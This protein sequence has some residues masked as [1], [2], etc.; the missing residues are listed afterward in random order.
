MAVTI[1]YAGTSSNTANSTFYKS[2]SI[3]AAVG[4]LLAVFVAASGT[5]QR[6]GAV[7]TSNQPLD[8]STF[9]LVTSALW[10]ASAN[11][12]YAYIQ[13]GFCTSTGSNNSTWVSFD[14][15]GDAATGAIINVVR[16][17]GM[18]K[19]SLGS[20]RQSVVSSNQGSSTRPLVTFSSL[21]F[22]TSAVIGAAATNSSQTQLS[23]PGGWSE[24][25]DTG[26][27]T[28]LTG[29]EIAGNVGSNSTAIRWGTSTSS[30]NCCLAVEFFA[31][32]PDPMAVMGAIL[33][34][35]FTY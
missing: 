28:P 31:D 14:C 2:S 8:G 12:L 15:V 19:V 5:T 29:M 21:T 26:Y 34:S 24:Y 23:P 35:M 6:P 25:A 17:T 10:G 16:L 3:P 30:L 11:S 13:D 9:T 18:S 1:T 20:V 4:D 33:E 27:T 32:A 7:T 22:V